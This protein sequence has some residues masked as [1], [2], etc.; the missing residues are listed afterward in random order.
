MHCPGQA[1]STQLEFSVCTG[2]IQF[3]KKSKLWILSGNLLSLFLNT[4]CKS[5]IQVATSSVPRLPQPCQFSLSIIQLR[6]PLPSPHLRTQHAPS[7]IPL[8]LSSLSS[9][10]SRPCPI[11]S[12]RANA[13]HPY[14]RT[15]MFLVDMANQSY[16]WSI[17]AWSL[18]Q[19]PSK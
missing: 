7:P 4:A 1:A 19:N 17:P 8:H 2:P 13:W 18:P 5:R 15:P 3:F 10:S 12:G 9:S 14:P 16:T 11:S 6:S